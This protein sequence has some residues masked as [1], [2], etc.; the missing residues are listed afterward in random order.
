MNDL[1][2]VRKERADQI[3]QH[4]RTE[5]ELK[6]LR[7]KDGNVLKRQ[8][9]KIRR[10]SHMLVEEEGRATLL[11]NLLATRQHNHNERLKVLL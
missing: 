5:A 8:R 3:A 7:T 6:A 2:K 10:L 11:Q 9:N 1:A 4:T